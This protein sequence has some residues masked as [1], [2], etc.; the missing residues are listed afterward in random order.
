MCYACS[1]PRQSLTTSATVDDQYAHLLTPS[2]ALSGV[3]PDEAPSYSS[4]TPEEVDAFLTEM[5]PDI[6]AAD[7]DLRE[8]N[9]LVK[10]G[11][12][13]SGKLGGGSSLWIIYVFSID[14]QM[15]PTQTM[16]NYNRG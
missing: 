11:V 16:R 2:F 1:H 5:E 6:R 14:H 10:K 4:L 15:H 8:I 12:T 7:S 3:L 13:S 9:E